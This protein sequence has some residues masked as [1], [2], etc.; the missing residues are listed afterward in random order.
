MCY[1]SVINSGILVWGKRNEDFRPIYLPHIRE[2][3]QIKYPFS[4]TNVP[5]LLGMSI[6]QILVGF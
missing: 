3:Y 6:G 2:N 5:F 4:L 1:V